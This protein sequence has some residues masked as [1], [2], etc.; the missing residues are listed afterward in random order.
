MKGLRP[1]HTSPE[2][3]NDFVDNLKVPPQACLQGRFLRLRT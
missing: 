1:L 3:M 2:F